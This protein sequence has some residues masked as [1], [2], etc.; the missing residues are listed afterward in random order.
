MKDCLVQKFLTLSHRK[1][2]QTGKE[3]IAIAY[4][5]NSNSHNCFVNIKTRGQSTKSIYGRTWFLFSWILDLGI[6]EKI[7]KWKKESQQ[8]CC[9]IFFRNLSSKLFRPITVANMICSHCYLFKN[10]LPFLSNS[11]GL[12]WRSQAMTSKTFSQGYRDPFQASFITAT[13]SL[14]P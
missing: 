3:L 14:W 2:N 1:E 8:I 10:Y 7:E 11:G 5:L 6:Q 9:C 4:A 12:L 13:I